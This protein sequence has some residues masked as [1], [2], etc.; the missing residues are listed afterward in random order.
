MRSGYQYRSMKT[1]LTTGSMGAVW[2]TYDIAPTKVHYTMFYESWAD[3]L[4]RLSAIIGG[5]FAAAGIFESLL[6][7]GFCM[8]IPDEHDSQKQRRQTYQ[9]V[10]ITQD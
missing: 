4:V 1:V 5:M 7:N 8:I 9:T 3:F 6:R 2:F 10:E